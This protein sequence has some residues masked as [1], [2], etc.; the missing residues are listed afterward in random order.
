MA[1]K[2]E[3]K[4][5]LEKSL[6]ALE[7]DGKCVIK[8]EGIFLEFFFYENFTHFFPTFIL[9]CWDAMENGNVGKMEKKDII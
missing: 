3:K 1:V 6:N 2:N 9:S 4:I 5:F 8:K 7:Q